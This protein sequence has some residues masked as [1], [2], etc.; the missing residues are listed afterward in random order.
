MTVY[1][2]DLICPD[3]KTQADA[4]QVKAALVMAPGFN[5]LDID[6]EAHHLTVSTANQD[7]GRD[8]LYRLSHAG[9]PAIDPEV[10]MA[11]AQEKHSD[12]E[13]REN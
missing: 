7:H 3:L 12:N 5:S 13:A 11:T 4:A 8:I 10:A 1:K 6:V 2:L 9:F